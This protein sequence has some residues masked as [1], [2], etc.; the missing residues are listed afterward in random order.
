MDVLAAIARKTSNGN[1]SRKN[2]QDIYES[3]RKYISDKPDSLQTLPSISKLSQTFNANY[4]TVRTALNKLKDEGLILYEQNVG[5]VVNNARQNKIEPDVKNAIAYIRWDG[6]ALC[7]SVCEGIR[8]FCSEGEV[9]QDLVILDAMKNHKRLLEGL[10]SISGAVDGVLLMPFEVSEYRQ[11]LQ[12]L[13]D[14]GTNVVF[15][16]RI[17][18]GVRNASSVT[19]DDFG[20]ALQVVSHLLDTHKRPVYYLGQTDAPSSVRNRYLGWLEAMN[21]YGYMATDAFCTKIEYREY[22]LSSSR[23]LGWAKS[24]ESAGHIFDGRKEGTY[25]VFAMN[26]YSAVAVYKAA[27]QRGLKIGKDVFVAGFG[28]MPLSVNSVPS[29]TTV[30]QN[31]TVLGYEGAKVLY[32]KTVGNIKYPINCILPVSMVIRESSVCSVGK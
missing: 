2:S 29:L 5:I 15:L 28:N 3:L 7:T 32:D 30:D 14:H 4:R 25:C 11:E 24:I 22:E 10:L 9:K 16:D 26:D 12:E 8:R 20:G 23:A 17:V 19:C 31:S 6:D 21:Q 27:A 13:I 1:G 18:P